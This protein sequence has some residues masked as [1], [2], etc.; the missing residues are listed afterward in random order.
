[1]KPTIKNL[2]CSRIHRPINPIRS[3]VVDD[4]ETMWVSP[5]H[6]LTH[7]RNCVGYY[8]VALGEGHPP[9]ALASGNHLSAFI[10]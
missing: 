8:V 2:T 1:M 5:D 10:G 3:R 6:Q 4:L 7:R 9:P